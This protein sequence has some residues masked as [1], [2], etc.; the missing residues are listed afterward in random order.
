MYTELEIF[1]MFA[2]EIQK[3]KFDI[4]FFMIILLYVFLCIS[5]DPSYNYLLNKYIKKTYIYHIV[6]RNL[7]LVLLKN[8]V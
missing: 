3:L 6:I 8:I 5:I 1:V 2:L 7:K 4:Y